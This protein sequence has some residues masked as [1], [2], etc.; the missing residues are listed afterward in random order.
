MEGKEPLMK[1]LP[2][3]VVS[4]HG[5]QRTRA[6]EEVVELDDADADTVTAGAEPHRTVTAAA[7]LCRQRRTPSGEQTVTVS[8][9]CA[10][11][12]E[13]QDKEAEIEATRQA[14][15]GIDLAIAKLRGKQD[16]TD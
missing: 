8:G 13:G 10:G 5:A 14:I 4:E 3:D 2:E 16:S 7:E 9:D 11:A 12:A 1:T 15:Q 6:E